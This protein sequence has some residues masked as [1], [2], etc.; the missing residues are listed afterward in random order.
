MKDQVILAADKGNATVVMERKDYDGKVLND[1]TAYPRL[2][3]DPTKAQDLAHVL[4]SK[5][6]AET[7]RDVTIDSD[8]SLV[9]FDVTSPMYPS[10]RQ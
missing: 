1:I 10:G 5:H 6:F 7:M 2:S 4:N 8:E 3:K 9:R